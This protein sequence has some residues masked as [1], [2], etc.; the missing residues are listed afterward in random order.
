MEINGVEIKDDFYDEGVTHV[1]HEFIRLCKL[2]NIAPET[3]IK[4]YH[5]WYESG[6]IYDLTRRA[7]FKNLVVKL[8]YDG[9]IATEGGNK[10]WG[11]VRANQV[12]LVSN[13]NPTDK[14]SMKEE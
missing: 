4:Y 10:T 11:C 8:G 2:V 13:E 3:M 5:K 7:F 14:D 12:K 9:V 1:S 6:C